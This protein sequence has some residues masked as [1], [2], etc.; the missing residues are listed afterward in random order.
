LKK[1][2]LNNFS[3]CIKPTYSKIVIFIDLFFAALLLY[4]FFQ[5]DFLMKILVGLILIVLIFRSVKKLY[6]QICITEKG[7]FFSLKWRILGIKWFSKKCQKSDIK[8]QFIEN[9]K[10]SNHIYFRGLRFLVDHG[11]GIEIKMNNKIITLPLNNKDLEKIE[12]WKKSI[13]LIN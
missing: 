4:A 13:S 8:I 10:D 2:S 1:A 5:V 7:N 12:N 3:V 9:I 6:S 11:K